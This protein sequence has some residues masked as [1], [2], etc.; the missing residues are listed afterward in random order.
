MNAAYCQKIGKEYSIWS[1]DYNGN[2]AMIFQGTLSAFYDVSRRY[3]NEYS[4]NWD[5]ANEAK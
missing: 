1:T 3:K 4:V 2:Y 5:G